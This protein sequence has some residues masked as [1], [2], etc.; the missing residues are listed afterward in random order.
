MAGDSGGRKWASPEAARLD[1]EKRQRSFIEDALQKGYSATEAQKVVSTGKPPHRKAKRHRRTAS[2]AFATDYG[3]V[4]IRAKNS[5]MASYDHAELMLQQ[6]LD[7]VRHR[8]KNGI[9]W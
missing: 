8:I 2:Q 1:G 5:K 3:E 9:R 7:E 6:A 4:T